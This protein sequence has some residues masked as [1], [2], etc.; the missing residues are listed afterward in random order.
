MIDLGVTRPILFQSRCAAG[1]AQIGELRI[2]W[3]SRLRR[4]LREL[5]RRQPPWTLV[6][7][8]VLDRPNVLAGLCFVG[9]IHFAGVFKNLSGQL[10]EQPRKIIVLLAVGPARQFEHA[11]GSLP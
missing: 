6:D 4:P 1:P 3:R 5:A 7:L 9:M 8:S 2:A 11:L 10:N